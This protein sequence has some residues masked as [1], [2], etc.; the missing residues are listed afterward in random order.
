[1]K[2]T[3]SAWSAAAVSAALLL[4]APAQEV[5]AQAVVGSA[6]LLEEIVVTARRREET[7][8]DLPVSVAAIS[9]DA[10]QAQGIYNI[11]QVGEFIP[12]LTFTNTDRRHV[13]AIY[14]RGIGGSSP[15]TVRPSGTGVYLDGMYLPNTMGMMLSTVDLERVEVMRGP[16]GTLFG[17]NTTGGAINLVTAKP[18]QEFEADVMM[19]VGDYG[20]Q[21]FKAM[22]NLPLSDSVAGR[23]SVS[24]EKHDGFYTNIAPWAGG[25][26]TGAADIDG[27]SAA[28]RFE[29]NDNWII[30]L[31]ARA[32]YHNDDDEAVQCRAAPTAKALAT[33]TDEY[34]AAAMA[35]YTAQTGGVSL[36]GAGTSKSTTTVGH[37]DALYDGA[38]L[39]FWN[40]CKAQN[41]AGDYVTSQGK[42]TF[43]KLDNE[44]VNATFQ[45]DSAGAIA[46]LDNLN[47]RLILGK[48]VTD[49]Q[50]LSDRDGTP[51]P[52]DTWYLTGPRGERRE[53]RSAEIL[54]TA[55]VNDQLSITTGYH[56]FDDEAQAGQRSQNGCLAIF[57]RNYDGGNGPFGKPTAGVT[58]S[59]GKPNSSLRVPC[60]QDGGHTMDFMSDTTVPSLNVTGRDGYEINDSD[61]VFGHLTYLL[62]DD[63]TID[64]GAR[65]TNEQRI[66]H[67]LEWD[68]EPG[69]CSHKGNQA[70]GAP[71]PGPQSGCMVDMVLDY[72]AWASRGFYNNTS[73]EF[74]E[75]TPMMSL[76][77]NI[78]GS[79]FIEDGMMYV[80]MSEGFLSGSFNDELNATLVPELAPLLSYDPEHVYNYEFGMKGTFLDGRMRLSGAVFYMDYQDKQEGITIDNSDGRYGPDSSLQITANASTV[81]ITGFEIEARLQPWDGGFITFDLGRL[82][83]EYG[84]Y[85][86]FD[87]DSGTTIDRSNLTIR[88]YS[89]EWT[90]NGSVEHVF[91]LANGASITPNFGIYYQSDYDF[92]SGV[93]KDGPVSTYC[94]QPGYQKIRGRIS[95]TPASANWQASV[96][97]ANLGDERYF[98]ICGK[99]RHGAFDY[100]YGNPS[101]IG[102]EFQYYWGN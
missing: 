91:M 84:E 70:S 90:F 79:D 35:G 21:D 73:M 1:M 44:F 16:Q 38:G 55:D 48:Q 57:E 18:S 101:S 58:N 22:I 66:F 6:S 45:W 13:K 85:G 60:L 12:N 63:W 100:R 9:A 75:V 96:F 34:G 97:G 37:V 102:V 88:D 43:L 20:Q 29:P 19:R 81:D 68:A 82:T 89:P 65:W 26:S 41:D 17:K 5:A 51:L 53:T 50:Y 93:D 83:N 76:S 59:A 77:R 11:D 32:N 52:L 4:S 2:L 3:N 94:H 28:L 92:V 64:A 42:D 86:A 69:T 40:Y 72:S 14:I 74:S 71:R 25:M 99:A 24:N 49:L 67:Q 95:Y 8:Q 7:L 87:P 56:Y 31:S 78:G 80:S 23:F 98:E 61:G 15:V 30:D 10:M 47:V 54:V 46:G 62:N 36:W 33:M 27:F 39:D